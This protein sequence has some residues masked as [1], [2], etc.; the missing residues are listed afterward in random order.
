VMIINI[1]A[2][3]VSYMQIRVHLHFVKYPKE[4][5]NES[6]MSGPSI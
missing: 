6:N 4:R 3:L 2:A 1:T 5:Q